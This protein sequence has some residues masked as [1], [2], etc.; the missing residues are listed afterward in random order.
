MLPAVL[1]AACAG[2]A[3]LETLVVKMRILVVPRL[4]AVGAVVGVLGIAAKLA[5]A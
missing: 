5:G 1:V 2:L 3:L 4:L